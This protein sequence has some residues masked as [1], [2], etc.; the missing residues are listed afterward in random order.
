M[1]SNIEPKCYCSH[2]LENQRLNNT[3]NKHEWRQKDGEPSEIICD[4]NGV[5]TTIGSC[6]ADE[7]CAGPTSLKDAICGRSDLCTKKCKNQL[8]SIYFMNRY[9][10]LVE[11]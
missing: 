5:R 11:A 6:E 8:F 1:I 9:Q 3:E 7:Y 10:N 4:I 2:D